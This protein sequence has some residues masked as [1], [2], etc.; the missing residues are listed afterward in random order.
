M[1]TATAAPSASA[2]PQTPAR[3]PAPAH[4][5]IDRSTPRQTV[6]GLL[7]AVSAGEL[8]R[9]A[10]YLELGSLRW[11]TQTPGEAAAQLAELLTLHVW[12]HP[13]SISDVPEGTPEDGVDVERVASI[14]VAGSDVP[15]TL[16]R[17]QRGG[18][19]I[20]LFSGH[21]VSRLPE[22]SSELGAPAWVKPLLPESLESSRLWGMWSWQWV[23]LL[24]ALLL[25]Y[26]LGYAIAT[27]M[28]AALLRIAARTTTRWDESALHAARPAARM[29]LG[30][31]GFLV[32]S[33]SLGLPG[34]VQDLLGIWVSIPVILATGWAVIAAVR[35]VIDVY[36]KAAAVDEEVATRGVR[37]HLVILRRIATAGLGFVTIAVALTRF[38]VVRELGISLL[39]SAGVAGVALGFAAQKSLGAA[40]AGLQ[41]SITQPVRIGDAIIWQGQWGVVEEITLTWVRLKVHDERRLV[42]P[43]DK[44]LNETFE[45]WSMPGTEMIGLVEIP[46]DPTAPVAKIRAEAERLARAHPTHDGRECLVQLI[47]VNERCAMLR[48]RVSTSEVGKLFAMRCELREALMD[49]L[50]QLD[51][52][53][54]LTRQRWESYAQAV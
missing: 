45:N 4:A 54:Y 42:V 30:L 14:R 43:V 21:I 39:A 50:Q 13:G 33:L 36:V 27:L 26:P 12:L 18:E 49:Y 23:A 41:L 8:A 29:A 15:I 10:Q 24:I 3:P 5:S 17:V 7:H 38:D 20:W 16:S 51:G 19:P 32:L 34:R 25:G 2:A 53:R 40:I 37:T 44:F 6:T 22:L 1:P 35:A 52:G 48:L 31:A 11:G 28:S 46:V 47:D 9:A